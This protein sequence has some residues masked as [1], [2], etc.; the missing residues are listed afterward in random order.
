MVRHSLSPAKALALLAVGLTTAFA[1][2]CGSEGNDTTPTATTPASGTSAAPAAAPGGARV[3]P[4]T[5]NPI[6]NTSTTD[7]LTIT[8]ALVENNVAADTGK[9]VDDHLEVELENTST[10]PLDKISIYYTITDPTTGASEHY[11]AE[12]PGFTIA[13][14]ASRIAHF[15]GSTATDHFP[16]NPY[17]LYYTDKNAL[18]IDVM[19]SSPTVKPATFTVNKD[20][21][22]AEAGVE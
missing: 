4:V 16:V 2:G 15:D 13:P 10:A 18:S 1:A 22:G 14:G 9:A 8:K 3:L 17:S 19:A 11:Y 7:G 6:T 20:A 21:G 5:T 12:L